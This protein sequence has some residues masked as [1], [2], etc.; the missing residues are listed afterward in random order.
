MPC[1]ILVAYQC[2][3]PQGEI[4]A[5]VGADHVF[6]PL[7]RLQSNGGDKTTWSRK[8]TVV[9]V[10]DKTVD[11]LSW[12]RDPLMVAGASEPTIHPSG[13]N[14]WYFAVPTVGTPQYDA[15]NATGEIE[16]P[17]SVAEQFLLERI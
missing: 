6:S 1:Q 4:V 10:S 12:L 14:R 8:F 17:W 16:C 13:L 11:E 3:K 2:Y 5:V 9:V 15:L 7:E